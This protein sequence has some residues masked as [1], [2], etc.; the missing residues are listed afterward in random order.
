[1]RAR[2]Q[3]PG[4]GFEVSVSKTVHLTPLEAWR[5]FVEPTRRMVWLDLELEMR[6]GTRTKGRAARFD[7]PSEQNRVNVTF[8]PKGDDR[9]VVTVTH[10][11]L[12]GPDD[13]E[14]HRVAWRARLGRL[15]MQATPTT[16]TRG[17]AEAS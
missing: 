15:A 13:V 9:S 10:V 17:V 2:N 14:A 1:M 4:E 11:K 12:G 3:R 6:T 16:V 7:V 8:F 5:A